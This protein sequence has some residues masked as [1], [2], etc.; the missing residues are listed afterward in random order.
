MYYDG[1]IETAAADVW[2]S[3]EAV[4]H[5]DGTT[6]LAL[7]DSANMHTLSPTPGAPP[8]VP[9]IAGDGRLFNGD[10]HIMCEGV[11]SSGL[12]FKRA[13]FSYS[14]W[15]DVASNVGV[16]D[17]VLACGGDVLQN[18]GFTVELG[19]YEW[20]SSIADGMSKPLV[21]LSAQPLVGWHHLAI[22]VDREAGSLRGYVDGGP[23]PPAALG[24]LGDVT[25]SRRLCM[26]NGANPFMGT[27]DEVRVYRDVLSPERVLMEYA[28][29]SDRSRF[30][31]FEAE[32]LL[33]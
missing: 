1:P 31:A 18:P 16:Y 25:A 17:S 10:E 26:S 29:L 5:M 30:L 24:M 8:A 13:S 12:D 22:V 15:V 6:P 4:W 14:L 19:M 9:A 7:R 3:Y 21:T 11:T 23:V 32:E 20:E 27:L 2:Q 33:R 28:N